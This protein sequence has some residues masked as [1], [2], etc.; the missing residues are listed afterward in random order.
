MTLERFLKEER[1]SE[2]KRGEKKTTRGVSTGLMV[3]VS[4]EGR[5]VH[6]TV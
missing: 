5:K 2:G 1:S 4:I 6:S 3:A